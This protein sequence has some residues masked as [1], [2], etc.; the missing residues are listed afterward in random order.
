MLKG[1]TSLGQSSPVLSRQSVSGTVASM[2]SVLSMG[3]GG[4]SVEGGAVLAVPGSLGTGKQYI[5]GTAKL[6]NAV[7]ALNQDAHTR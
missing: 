1:R 7:H 4:C 2:S 6:E 5:C 3:P